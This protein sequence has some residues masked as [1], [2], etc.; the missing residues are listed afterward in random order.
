MATAELILSRTHECQPNNIIFLPIMLTEA[1]KDDIQQAYSR[2]LEARGFKA[3]SC[4]KH[5]IAH[6]AR[7][8]GN[9]ESDDN[10]DRL[11]GP[12]TCVVEAGTGTG[13]TIAYTLASLPV[14]R[15]LGKKL[16]ISTATVALQ[17]QIIYQD[18][19]D[20]RKHAELDVTFALA[21]G[22]RRYLCLA[23]LDHA[24]QQV[25]QVNQSLAL[26]DDDTP[27]SEV[28]RE[29]YQ[30]MIESLGRGDW[31][32]DRDNWPEE[33]ANQSWMP[34]STD[35]IR[36]TGRQCS[37][38][39]N[40]IFYRAREQIHRVDCIVTNHDLVL[41]DLMMG[42]GAVLPAPEDTIY[43][44]D[45]GH[46]LPDKATNHFSSFL[47]V[48]ATQT[49]LEQIPGSLSL[50]ST[51]LTGLLNDHLRNVIE[52]RVTDLCVAL[53]A[54]LTLTE[55]LQEESSK[56]GE[57]L[58]YRFPMGEVPEEIRELASDLA[59]QFESLH[60]VLEGLES[61][62]QT[63]LEDADAVQQEV[64]EHWMPIVSGITARLASSTMLWML[65]RR[66]DPENQPPYARWIVFIPE[67]AGIEVQLHASPISVS[68]TL[69]D[70]L[71]SRCYGVVVTSAT[72][73]VGADFS[74]YQG[75]SGISMDNQFNTLPSPFD[76]HTQ[77][78]LQ[79]P[80][81]DADPSDPDA[82]T[83]EITTLIPQ[84]LASERSSLVLFTSW[85]QM[86]GVAARLEDEF[87]ACV[88][89][90]GDLSRSEIVRTHK[91]RIDA[92]ETSCIFG[93]ASF[94]E[95]IDLPGNYCDHVVIC[96]IPFAVPDDP[97]GATLAEWIEAAG[98][99]SFEEIMIPDAALRMV[100]AC[101]RL[102]R[103]ET[104]TGTISILDRR[105]VTRRYGKKLQAALPPFRTEIGR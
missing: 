45:E 5:M 75:R 103:T 23:R 105:L 86:L 48:R 57:R 32:G 12:N 24:L 95:G 61:A 28:D 10:G 55:N 49:W 43:V 64:V 8:L 34:V 70:L 98:G 50:M 81:M 52:T 6:I 94:A 91:S 40:C 2:L 53:E 87:S 73:S 76:Y 58:S 79:I 84:L 9:I 18:L 101:G 67:D 82:H 21:K 56:D 42:G 102:L 44:F 63:A 35:H 90:Q 65:Y 85:R 37:H 60:S 83:Q 29:L 59:R 97:I 1:L 3:R 41:A 54:V 4:Q 100:Q 88:L 72:L 96:K 36:C 19:P 31:N 104:D 39:D 26:F 17:E 11:P 47:Q 38:Y 74:R 20:I 13:K 16:V 99:N 71:W 77:G 66:P 7:V 30:E 22:R 89:R 68:E 78:L 14:A 62:V 33:I 51:E 92:G 93:L 27:T 15:A 46:H 69:Q 25:D 80:S